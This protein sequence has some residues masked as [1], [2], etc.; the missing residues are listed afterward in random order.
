MTHRRS[1]GGRWLPILLLAAMAPWAGPVRAGEAELT[2]SSELLRQAPAVREKAIQARLAATPVAWPAGHRTLNEAVAALAATGNATMLA[3]GMDATLAGELPALSGDYWQGVVAVCTAFDLLLQ[4]G[5]AMDQSEDSGRYANRDNAG[6]PLVTQGGAVV[7]M[8]RPEKSPHPF[9]V[10]SGVVLAEVAALELRQRRGSQPSRSLDTML[11]LR[12]EPHVL[13]GQIGTTLVSWTAAEDASGRKLE[14][15]EPAAARATSGT[16]LR[17]AKLPER[18]TGL[19]LNGE[20]A[21]QLLEPVDLGCVLKLGVGAR[22]ELLGQ[23]VELRLLGDG[24]ATVGGQKGPGLSVSVPTTVLGARPHV[25]VMSAG[26]LLPF[27]LQGSQWS[28]GRMELFFRGPK[29]G[30]GD[31]SV[32]IKGQAA[33][34]QPHLPLRLAFSFDHLPDGEA[35]TAQGFELQIPTHLS[36]PAAPLAVRDAVKLLAANGN[37]ALLELGVEESRAND[38]PA[39]SGTFWEGAL[40]LCRAYD[41]AIVPPSR[42]LGE[43]DLP[44]E[45][46]ENGEP[47]PMTSCIAGGQL[48]LGARRAGRRDGDSYQA[49]GI[50]LMGVEDLSVTTNQTLGGVNRQADISFR[51]RLEPRFDAGLIGSASVA[52]T[53]LAG[54]NDGRALVVDDA[55]ATDN[56]EDQRQ[57]A[58]RRM[59]FVRMGRRIVQVPAQGGEPGQGEQSNAGAVSVTGLPAGP[60]TLT[61]GGQATLAL[62]REV[63]AEVTLSPGGHS[64]AQ[65]GGHA[66]AVRL[67]TNGGGEDASGRSGVSVDQGSETVD[68][69]N[70]EVR[71]A[72]GKSLRNSDTSTNSRN[73]RPRSLWYFPDLESGDYTVIITAKEHLATLRLPFTLTTTTP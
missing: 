52:W 56:E 4:P 38:L 21:A 71:N 6:S 63:R 33:L 10:S 31:Y 50:L 8:R 5:E 16:A 48:V 19:Q 32:S 2:V 41:L 27:T 36:W 37:Q 69:L 64:V 58:R 13:P 18:F 49:C 20:L 7:L 45:V 42:P 39:F 17:I 35:A 59:R 60:V 29:L 22:T 55:T 25:Q 40:A 57:R 3:A 66:L 11:E 34:Q 44:V 28:G 54:Q 12:F 15:A 23:Q 51:L 67:F 65:I 53:T 70:V 24:D 43:G 1:A 9:Y 46:D 68:S 47:L 30:D 62:R 72:S 26:N 61:V 73:G 14:L